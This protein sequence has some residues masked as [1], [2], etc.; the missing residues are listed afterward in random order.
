MTTPQE[1]AARVAELREKIKAHPMCLRFE[2][3]PCRYRVIYPEGDWP[4]GIDG[5][6]A[7]TSRSVSH[8]QAL[9][10]LLDRME[11]D[12]L[13]SFPQLPLTGVK[14]DKG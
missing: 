10:R 11:R 2:Q 13:G 9:T 1:H 7:R 14:L 8:T 5:L 6:Q 4:A 3:R 12:W